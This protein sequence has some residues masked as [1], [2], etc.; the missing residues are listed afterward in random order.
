M[1]AR[2][3][4]QFAL[5]GLVVMVI[6]GCSS[7]P[8]PEDSFYRLGNLPD[9]ALVFETPPVDGR[10][11]IEVPRAAGIRRQRGILYS[12][13]ADHVEVRRYYYHFWEEPPPQMLQ[14]RLIERLRLANLAGSI[15]E[16][17]SSDVDFRLRTRIREF[18]RRVDG[19]DMSAVIDIDVIL[20]TGYAD[21]E[22][23]FRNTYRQRVEADSVQMVDTASAFAQ[24]LDQ[25]IDQF[26]S[27]VREQL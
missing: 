17:L 23:I 26:L 20:F 7:T 6:V 16:G 25:V 27:D 8:V 4:R 19:S 18:D 12:E 21:G 5:A 10:L 13:D 9:P 3:C 24:A 22:A 14:R 1:M 11:M 15:T 2:V